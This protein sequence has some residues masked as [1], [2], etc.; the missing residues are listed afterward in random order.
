MHMGMKKKYWN[1]ASIPESY[2]DLLNIVEILEKAAGEGD[3]QSNVTITVDGATNETVNLS[4]DRLAD[5]VLVMKT[6]FN[7]DD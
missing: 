3:S 4:A 5:I 6:A 2:S 7:N 1:T